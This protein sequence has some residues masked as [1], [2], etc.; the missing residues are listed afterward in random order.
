MAKAEASKRGR[1]RPK[2]HQVEGSGLIDDT[3]N[4]YVGKERVHKIKTAVGE[5][6]VKAGKKAFDIAKSVGLVKTQPSRRINSMFD[7]I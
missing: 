7:T 3:L 6:L 2:K 4:K 1:G 5:Q